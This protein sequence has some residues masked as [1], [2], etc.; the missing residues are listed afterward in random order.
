MKIVISEMMSNFIKS[1]IN[2]IN[3]NQWDELYEKANYTVRSYHTIGGFTNILLE[4]GI[5][6]LLQGATYI[7]KNYLE[8]SKKKEF[9]IPEISI[10]YAIDSF[11]FFNSDIE[12]LVIPSNITYIN[13]M[14]FKNM[15]KLKSLIWDSK[16]PVIPTSCFENCV[17]LEKLIL[18][19]YITSIQANAFY[20]TNIKEIEYQGTVKEWYDNVKLQLAGNNNSHIVNIKCIDGDIEI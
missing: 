8:E 7:P 15:F 5:D 20:N 9:T 6:P 13:D 11:A 2:L 12:N 17:E 16:C 1:N 19:K 18:P 4:S 3:N 10:L 14:A